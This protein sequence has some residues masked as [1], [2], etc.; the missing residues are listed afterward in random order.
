MDGVQ[1]HGK[2][3]PLKHEFKRRIIDE[4]ED[5]ENSVELNP[6]EFRNTYKSNAGK[7]DI[8]S[9]FDFAFDGRLKSSNLQFKLGQSY[10]K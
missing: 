10:C 8:T 3:P 7:S 9:E 4:I 6:D 5:M 2:L 1:R